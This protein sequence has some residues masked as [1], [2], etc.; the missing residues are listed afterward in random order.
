MEHGLGARSCRN[1]IGEHGRVCLP[2]SGIRDLCVGSRRRSEQPVRR[3]LTF[4]WTR[5]R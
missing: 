3:V 2:K 1:M 4:L 5:R